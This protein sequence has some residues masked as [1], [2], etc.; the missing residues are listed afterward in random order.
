MKKEGVGQPKTPVAT[1]LKFKVFPIN[2]YELLMANVCFWMPTF[3]NFIKFVL[4]WFIG[5][6]Q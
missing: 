3:E 6:I 5:F 1:E 4:F 2:F